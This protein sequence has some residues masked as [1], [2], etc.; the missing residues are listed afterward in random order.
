[1]SVTKRILVQTIII[2]TVNNKVLLG[3]HKSGPDAGHYTGLLG[4]PSKGEDLETAAIR[5]AAEQAGVIIE[6][7]KLRTINTFN[8]DG[9]CEEEYDY[10]CE[11]FTGEPVE[12]ET[13]RPEWFALDAIPYKQM[14]ADDEVWYP[15]FLQ[16]K[17]LRGEFNFDPEMQVMLSHTLTEVDTLTS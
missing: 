5:L 11:S 13:I 17:L 3:F 14:P 7:L 4:Y 15:P 2:D 8:A 16:G 1:M 9:L 6:N 12:T 10:Y